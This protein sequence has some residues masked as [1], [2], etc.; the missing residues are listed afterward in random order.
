M[1][2]GAAIGSVGA[3]L[4][5]TVVPNAAIASRLGISDEWIERRTWGATVV[6]WGTS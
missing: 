5:A 4:P 6:E 3:S 2:A 1:R